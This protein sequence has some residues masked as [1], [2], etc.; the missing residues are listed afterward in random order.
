KEVGGATPSTTPALSAKAKTRP[1]AEAAEP[2]IPAPK[3]PPLVPTITHRIDLEP[4]DWLWATWRPRDRYVMPTPA[5]QPFDKDACLERLRSRVKVR[6]DDGWW[7]WGKIKLHQPLSAEEA[8]FWAVAV[9]RTQ[10]KQNPEK[11]AEKLA[12]QDFDGQV[13]A[14]DIDAWVR[15]MKQQWPEQFVILWQTIPALLSPESFLELILDHDILASHWDAE[16]RALESFTDFIWPYLT[17]DQIERL[18]SRLRGRLDPAAWDDS[19]QSPQSLFFLLGALLGMHE[20]ML[21]LVKTW[22]DGR[23]SNLLGSPFVY[24]WVQ[25]QRIVFGLSDARQVEAHMRRLQLRLSTSL[26]VRAWLVNTEMAG[27]DLVRDSIHPSNREHAEKLLTA[28]ALVKAPEAAPHML[29]LKLNSKAPGLARQWLDDN[30]GNTIAGLIP[31]AGGRGKLAE[32]ALDYL[33]EAKRQGHGPF[34]VE[35]LKSASAEIAARVRQEVMERVEVIREAFEDDYAAPAWLRTALTKGGQPIA[36]PSWVSLT[37]LPPLIV[38]D[39]R[40]NDGQMSA[41]LSALRQS[42]LG[43]PAQLVKAI[44]EHI[45]PAVRDAFA[46]KLFEMWLG[47]GAPSKEK[48]ALL[49]VGHLGGDGSALKLTPLLRAWPGESQHQRAV[50]GLECLR[51]IGSDTALMQLNGIAQKLKFQG[52]KKKAQE[53]MEA[54]ATDRG[55]SRTQ[56]EDRIVPDLDLDERG[57]R[58]FDFGPR[59]F[60]VVLDADLKPVV[61]DESGKLKSDLPKP[62][63]KDDADKAKAALADWKILKK[64]LR[65]AI[66]VQAYRLEQAMVTGRRWNIQEFEQLLVRHPLMINLVRRLVWFGYDKKGKLVRTFRVTEE[67]DYA[68]SRDEKATLD[69]LAAVGIVHPLHLSEDDRSAWGQAF[70]DYEIFSPFPQLGRLVL[71]LEAHETKGRDIKRFAK[72]KIPGGAFMGTM[73]KLGWTRGSASDH[74]VIQEFSKQF[75]AANVTAVI[76]NQEGIPLSLGPDA[77]GDQWIER[78]YFLRGL[79]SPEGSGYDENLPTLADIDPLVISEVLVDLTNLASKGT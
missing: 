25:P 79:Y 74:G 31:V 17:V 51:T 13:T 39:R 47:E 12:R 75:P 42:P 63:A 29:E 23:Y 38:G 46:W 11:L 28:F 58:V 66:K 50:T 62:G 78:C 57:T 76:E 22:P 15:A 4:R 10:P 64:Q 1:K 44:K 24:N 19:K 34:I 48:W 16:S 3:P 68:D 67:R 36:L 40:L 8:H 69:G 35:Q 41:V 53:F 18:R 54:I 65:E 32:A 72:V 33:R 70:G 52:L 26:H 73:E 30:P 5:P 14:T 2:A 43:T 61:R 60:T 20:E 71:A 9:T 45:D 55:M 56:L 27:L 59:Q 77:F 21:A 6:V 49:A 37:N 7:D